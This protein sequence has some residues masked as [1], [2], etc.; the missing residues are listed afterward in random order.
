MDSRRRYR[1]RFTRS[2]SKKLFLSFS[3]VAVLALKEK[4][5][6]ELIWPEIGKENHIRVEFGKV[7]ELLTQ[8]SLT[9]LK[10]RG[11]LLLALISAT[12]LIF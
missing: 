11:I 9:Q 1:I 10:L 5:F 12:C 8:P 6:Q 2:L 3:F 4:T 7:L